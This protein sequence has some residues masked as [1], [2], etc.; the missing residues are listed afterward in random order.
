MNNRLYDEFAPWFHLLTHPKDYAEEA[1]FYG[2]ELARVCSGGPRRVLELGSG[3][4]NNAS[5]MKRRYDELVL[6]DLSPRMLEL[7]KGLNPECE[8]V[9]GDMR[10]LRLGRTFD[11][12]LIHDAIGYMTSEDDL[13]AAFE[14]AWLH[15]KPGGALLVAPDC[16]RETFS[17]SSKSGGHDGADRSLR[18]LEWHWDPDPDDCTYRTTFVYML[19]EGSAAPRVE[20]DQHEMGVFPQATWVSLL[21]ETGFR[22]EIRHWP[23]WDEDCPSQGIFVCVRPSE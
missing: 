21:E 15:T 20:I 11:A 16:V 17:E 9:Q 3:G 23:E 8:H 2:D 13:R 14:T 5:H 18:Y 10:S 19:R 7:S 4:G 12:V 1:E 22:V 6:S